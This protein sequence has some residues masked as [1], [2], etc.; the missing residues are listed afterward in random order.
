MTSEEKLGEALKQNKNTIEIEGD[1]AK[2]VLKM[3][4]TG[5]VAWGACIIALA[6]VVTSLVTTAATGGAS[7]AVTGA[8][9]ASA[10]PTVVAVWGIPVTVSAI[11]I[12]KAGGSIDVLKKLRKYQVKKISDQKIVLKKN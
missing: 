9:V 2:K 3:K 11:S 8:F 6:I 7:I 10:A 12:A 5:D 4:A 1:L